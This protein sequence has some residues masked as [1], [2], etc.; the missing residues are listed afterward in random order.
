VLRSFEREV[1]GVLRERESERF[2]TDITTDA[3]MHQ[4]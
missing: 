3:K 4:W 1:G 2:T